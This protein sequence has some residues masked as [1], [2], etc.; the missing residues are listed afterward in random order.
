MIEFSH[1]NK[2]FGEHKAVSDLN[3]HVKEGSFSVLIGTSGSGKS[4][5]LKMINRLVEHDS[6]RIRFAGEEIRSLPV[7]ELRRRMGYAI[8]SI[9][10]FPHWTVA[11]N[12]ATVPQLLKWPRRKIDERVEEL[13]ALLGLEVVLRERYPHQLSGGQQQRVGVARAL[14]ADPQVLLMDEPFGALDPVTRGALQQEMTRI[15]RLLGRTIVLVTHDIDEA[16][17]LAE[18]LVLMDG[19]EVVQQGTPLAMLTAPANDFVQQFFGRS[20][21]GVRLLSLRTVADYVRRDEQIAGEAL[22]EEMTLRDALS[23]F[24][25]RGCDVLPVVNQQGIVCGTLHFRD[26]L[27]ETLT[28][29]TTV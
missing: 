16:L 29:E 10:L 27:L 8:Q 3:L 4:T 20:E 1:V 14:A 26:L 5:T 2:A 21:L 7:L 17:R 23:A 19:G 24:V 18:H 28:H 9:G 15:H 22:T 25:A 13:M 11:Q 12:I 6:G